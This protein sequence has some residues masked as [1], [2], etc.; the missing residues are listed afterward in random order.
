MYRRYYQRYDNTRRQ[1]NPSIREAID[2]IEDDNLISSDDGY[3]E[4]T[5]DNYI[6]NDNIGSKAEIIVPKKTNPIDDLDDSGMATE[7]YIDSSDENISDPSGTI[8]N[9]SR[10]LLF[11]RF[12]IDDLLILALIFIFMLEGV[13]DPLILILLVFL[14]F[15]G[16]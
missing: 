10:P 2:D 16:F 6:D 5:D 1:M 3:D 13:Q 8:I 4:S 12:K 9:T 14:L 7:N 11:G 15:M